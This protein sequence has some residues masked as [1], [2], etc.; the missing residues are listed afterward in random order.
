M[1]KS[2][3]SEGGE[4]GLELFLATTKFKGWVKKFTSK[5]GDS[6]ENRCIIHHSTR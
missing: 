6:Q 1:K 2:S 5:E 3:S 4:W